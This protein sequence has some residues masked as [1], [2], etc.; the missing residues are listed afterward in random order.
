MTIHF[1]VAFLFNIV[2]E[3]QGILVAMF[4]IST[5]N[6]DFLN[7]LYSFITE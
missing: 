6:K 2:S 5:Q 4:I 3:L 1:A 7:I